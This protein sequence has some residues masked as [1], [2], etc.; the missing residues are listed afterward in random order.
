MQILGL[1]RNGVVG[2]R[3]SVIDDEGKHKILD[4]SLDGIDRDKASGL[5]D[6]LSEALEQQL[7]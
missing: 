2:I 1:K 5:R 3:F 6:Q 4:F 7:I